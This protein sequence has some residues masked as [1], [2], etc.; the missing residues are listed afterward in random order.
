MITANTATTNNANTLKGLLMT[1]CTRTV[2]RSMIAIPSP[3]CS[4]LVYEMRYNSCLKLKNFSA[5][6]LEI[7]NPH[8]L[9]EWPQLNPIELELPG[10][11]S[12]LMIRQHSSQ[13]R[14]DLR[15]QKIMA[16]RVF[17]HSFS[18]SRLWFGV[19]PPHAL[20]HSR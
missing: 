20:I 14:F 11:S 15:R 12:W 16:A 10:L 8:E 7:I 13:L 3:P 18:L 1:G 2:V 9:T 19:L 6:C 17:S 4:F 5:F